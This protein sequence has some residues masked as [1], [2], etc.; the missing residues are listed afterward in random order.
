MIFI[1]VELNRKIIPNRIQKLVKI[2]ESDT[3]VQLETDTNAFLET[4]SFENV[5][6]VE[7]RPLLTAMG[8]LYTTMI[9]YR[10]SFEAEDE[11]K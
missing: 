9:F 7:Y 3:A 8:T 11:L 10:H 4:I 5:M 6:N 2:I 1:L